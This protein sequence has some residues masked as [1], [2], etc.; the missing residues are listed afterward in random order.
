MCVLD[1]ATGGLV[2]GIGLEKTG[3]KERDGF[4]VLLMFRT[5]V[6]LVMG[7]LLLPTD[8]RTFVFVRKLV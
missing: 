1:I 4:S 8:A 7:F 6:I 5:G 2:K 3:G